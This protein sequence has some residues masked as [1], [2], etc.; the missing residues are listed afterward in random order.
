MSEFTAFVAV[1]INSGKLKFLKKNLSQCHF[2]YHKT[3][4]NCPG[5]RSRPLQCASI[6]LPPHLC[7]GTNCTKLH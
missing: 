2:I 3:D 5:H 7:C 6:V 4:M 1:R